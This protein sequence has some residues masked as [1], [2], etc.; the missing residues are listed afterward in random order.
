MSK[1]FICK[2]C[3]ET[4]SKRKSYVYEDGRACKKHQ[5]ALEANKQAEEKKKRDF[6]KTKNR[7][8]FQEMRR[9]DMGRFGL[10]EGTDLTMKKLEKYSPENP[11]HPK[12]WTCGIKGMVEQD[13][14]AR[15]LIEMQKQ[16]IRNEN[17]ITDKKQN[18]LEDLIEVQQKARKGLPAILILVKVTE[19]NRERILKRTKFAMRQGIDLVGYTCVCKKC[20]KE[21]KIENPDPLENVNLDQLMK[22]GAAYDILMKPEVKKIA[23]KEIINEAEEN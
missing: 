15:M 13:Y 7:N 18:F 22:V 23:Q 6:E 2:I 11:Y 19:E 1:E 4:V 3:G 14:A 5:E 12:C 17:P 21:L 9:R 16:E 8:S 20:A 10:Q